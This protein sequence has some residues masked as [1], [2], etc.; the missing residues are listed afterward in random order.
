MEQAA[1]ATIDSALA[2]HKIREHWLSRVVHDF[3]GPIFTSRGYAK[4]LLDRR[5]GDVTATQREYLHNILEAINKLSALV[6]A[7]HEFPSD[8]ALH[9]E[10]VD[11]GDLLRSA[12]ADWRARATTLRLVETIPPGAIVTAADEVRLKA[13]VH[14]LLACAVEFSQSAGEVQLHVSR[15]D[16]EL[17]VKI[18]ATRISAGEA[19]PVFDVQIPCEIL[20]LHGGVAQ[21][22]AHSESRYHVTVRLPLLTVES[23]GPESGR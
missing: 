23:G 21:V 9:L 2:L 10:P 14:K 22:H 11:L 6:D 12:T 5:A 15:E 7:L 17:S 20:R 19:P 16:D 3:R 13:A 18:A 8:Q 1:K 4:L